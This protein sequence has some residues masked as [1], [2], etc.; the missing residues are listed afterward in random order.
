MNPLWW[1]FCSGRTTVRKYASAK[2]VLPFLFLGT[3]AI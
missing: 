3:L 2:K 1:F